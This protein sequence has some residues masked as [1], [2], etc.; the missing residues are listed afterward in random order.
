MIYVVLGT[1]GFLV[2]HLFD[3]IS[4]KRWPVLKPV[5]WISGSSLLLYALVKLSTQGEELPLPGWS[6]WAGWFLLLTSL[7]L[8][9]HSL[10]IN[11][12]FQKTYVA[13]G[14]GDRLVTSGLYTLVRHPGVHWFSLALLS[15]V[16]VSRS[17]YLLAAAPLFIVLDVALVIIQDRFF[18][19]RM[20]SGYTHYQET[21]PMLI[22]NR[23][24]IKAFVNSLASSIEIK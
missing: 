3:V 7:F 12:P 20:F 4:L 10:F 11:L 5:T 18:F 19:T 2:I 8:L 9:V 23:Q 22:P 6:T 16:L 13:S 21:T 24:S 17:G 1:T 15:L 14:V